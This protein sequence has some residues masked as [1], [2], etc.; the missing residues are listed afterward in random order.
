MAFFISRRKNPD[1]VAALARSGLSGKDLSK[2]CG[3]CPATVS[4]VICCRLS[5]TAATINKIAAALKTTPAAL[6]LD[7]R[8]A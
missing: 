7:G 3:L 8:C 4:R 1:L 6:G 2:Q 5:P